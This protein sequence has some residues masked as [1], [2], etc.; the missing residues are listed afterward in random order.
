MYALRY[1]VSCDEALRRSLCGATIIIQE[2]YR[3]SASHAQL[4]SASPPKTCSHDALNTSIQP[5]ECEGI[6]KY[7]V[8]LYAHMNTYID[9]VDVIVYVWI[10]QRKFMYVENTILS[11]SLFFVSDRRLCAIVV[12]V[13]SWLCRETWRCVRLEH[14]HFD[15]HINNS[16]V[17]VRVGL[18][19]G[20]RFYLAIV[21]LLH[22]MCDVCC[23][24][25][26]CAYVIFV[27]CVLCAVM[28]SLNPIYIRV[29]RRW[30]HCVACRRP[31]AK[32]YTKDLYK[33]S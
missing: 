31:S 23:M 1:A 16:V 2:C 12:V 33:L 22:T 24:C 25:V 18:L 14:A 15:E 4:E 26:I 9:Y 30:R 19:L 3:F 32:C 28:L 13:W 27:R 10:Y 5:L 7:S 17:M 11:L 21:L 8:Y 29:R 6:Y 20:G